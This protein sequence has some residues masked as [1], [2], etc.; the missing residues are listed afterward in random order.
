[1]SAKWGALLL[2]TLVSLSACT[3][4]P[5][6]DGERTIGELSAGSDRNPSPVQRPD[7]FLM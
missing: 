5:D 1:M 3:T 4:V 7:E 6:R 2:G